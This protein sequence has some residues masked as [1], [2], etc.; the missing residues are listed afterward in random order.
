MEVTVGESVSN[1]RRQ[2]ENLLAVGAGCEL[3][4]QLEETIG[5]GRDSWRS[6]KK[7]CWQLE[8]TVEGVS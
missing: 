3:D 4:E 2:L 1:W 6:R 8:E 7:V 5:G